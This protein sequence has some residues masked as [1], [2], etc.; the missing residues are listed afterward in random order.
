MRAVLYLTKV[1]N[2]DRIFVNADLKEAFEELASAIKDNYPELDEIAPDD[3]QKNCTSN[4]II[5]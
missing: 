3:E 1:G 2:F 5:S 4:C